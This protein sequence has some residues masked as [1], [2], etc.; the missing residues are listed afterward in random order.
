MPACKAA[1]DRI[2]AS[3]LPMEVRAALVS[4]VVTPKA[5]YACAASPPS[6]RDVA[7]LKSACTRAIWGQANPWRAAEVVHGLLCKGHITAP[8]LAVQ[9][10]TITTTNRI[11]R[12]HPELVPV[13]LENVRLRAANPAPF[14]GPAKALTK[15]IHAIGAQLQ[16]DGTVQL[17]AVEQG[18]S[19]ALNSPDLGRFQHLV[20]EGQR[21]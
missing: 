18:Q 10:S 11:L 8:D 20:R 7:G 4:S 9:Y 19:I 17:P 6:K 15:S 2:E 3:N 14:G 13:L 21:V 5:A 1:C 16:Q 12:R